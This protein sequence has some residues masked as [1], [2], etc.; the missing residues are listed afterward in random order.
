LFNLYMFNNKCGL[1]SAA[2]RS[3]RSA[4]CCIP[5][6]L[7]STTDDQLELL[8]VAHWPAHKLDCREKR[9]RLADSLDNVMVERLREIQK[10]LLGQHAPISTRVEIKVFEDDDDESRQAQAFADS[11]DTRLASEYAVC[12]LAHHLG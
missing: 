3:V 1:S 10:P 2:L 5:G 4:T 11:V 7:D 8:Q 12:C 6:G 9:Q